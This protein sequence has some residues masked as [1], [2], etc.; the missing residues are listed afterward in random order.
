MQVKSR[1]RV[2]DHGEVFT[3]KREVNAMLDLVK[4]ETERIDSRFL[5]PACGTGNFLSEILRRKLNIVEGRY[6]KSQIEFEFNAIIAVS[7]IYGIEILEDNVIECR[8]RLLNIFLEEYYK[9][10]FSNSLKQDCI[11]SA[12]FILNKNIVW[13][14]ALTLKT[15]GDNLGNIIFC[16]WSPFNSTEIIRRDFSY[17][18]L[19]PN[20]GS[21]SNKDE[22][23]VF[24]LISDMGED[25]YIPK[26]IRAFKSI[27]FLELQ[28]VR[29]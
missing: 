29:D 6:K 1:Q 10:L 16:E 5:E 17:E 20:H 3:N 28:Y 18:T 25:V 14:D 24:D 4:P 8:K 9:K 19:V 7:S 27:H 21:N 12:R 13:G 23:D 2:A 22:D 26:P 11:D 15:L